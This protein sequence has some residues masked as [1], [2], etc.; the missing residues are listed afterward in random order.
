MSSA[1]SFAP[2]S[3][4]KSEESGLLFS[5]ALHLI[6]SLLSYKADRLS[7]HKYETLFY[8]GNIGS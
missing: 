8:I 1:A 7:E 5:H 3:S 6:I 4:Q 2:H